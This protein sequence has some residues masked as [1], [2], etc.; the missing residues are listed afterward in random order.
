[1]HIFVATINFM[2]KTKPIGVRFDLEKLEFIQ[3]EQNLK[4]PQAVVNFLI[5]NYGKIKP[6]EEV[7]VKKPVNYPKEYKKPEIK[8]Q[9]SNPEPPAG[10]SWI[11]LKIWKAENWK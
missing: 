8:P 5:D 10:L 2:A 7:L 6:I 11:D 9:N 4:T 3:K 1:M